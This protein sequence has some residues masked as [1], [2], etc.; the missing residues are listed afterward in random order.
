MRPNL[1]QQPDT[2]SIK[3]FDKENISPEKMVK[4]PSYT[5]KKST[6]ARKTPP[7]RNQYDQNK[8]I[9]SGSGYS[10][11]E[12]SRENSP[13]GKKMYIN[14]KDEKLQSGYYSN[15]P[16]ANSGRIS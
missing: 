5:G 2:G 4:K 8:R 12:Y 1:V 7:G 6:Q 14:R 11:A 16:L 13:S 10:K 3:Y 9:S 15:P